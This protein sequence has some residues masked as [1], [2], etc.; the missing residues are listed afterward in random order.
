MSKTGL[1]A[2]NFVT[3]SSIFVAC[4]G[5]AAANSPRSNSSQ[6]EDVTL[7]QVGINFHVTLKNMAA[8]KHVDNIDIQPEKNTFNIP[9]KGYVKCKKSKKIEFTK[10]QVYFGT[11]KRVG[12][13]VEPISVLHDATYHPSFAEWTGVFGGWVTEAGNSDPFVVPLNKVKNGHPAIRFDPLA[14]F[15]EKLQAHING[16]GSKIEFLK[17]DQYINVNRPISLAGTCREAETFSKSTNGSGY[18]TASIP[19]TIMYKGDAKIFGGMGGGN[20]ANQLAAPFQVT[21]ASVTP[22]IKD[23]V[24]KCPVDL[25][26]RVAFNAQGSGDIKFRLVSEQGAKGPIKSINITKN[27]NGVKVFDFARSI[28]EAKQGGFDNTKLATP[29]QN[30][31]SI[32]QFAQQPMTKKT[33]SWRVELVE[34]KKMITEE[35]YYS[36]KCE[37]PKGPGDIKQVK[38]KRATPKPIVPE[39]LIIN[40]N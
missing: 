1:S 37:T 17:Q 10:A 4:I 15:N 26:F 20:I 6:V 29:Q 36:W 32:N 34:P 16:G 39:G 3:I 25:K 35:S 27:D 19:L 7:S 38:P 33:G 23:Y 2:K 30:N 12:K 28:Q 13:N 22:H 9:L 8:N 21:S 14:L 40:T 11:V 24:G 5:S 31:G 18:I